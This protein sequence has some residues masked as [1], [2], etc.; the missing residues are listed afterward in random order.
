[1]K[2]LNAFAALFILL[3]GCSAEEPADTLNEVS[4]SGGVTWKQV[5]FRYPATGEFVPVSDENAIQIRISGEDVLM[6]TDSTRCTGKISD[7]TLSFDFSCS[8][9]S[10]VWFIVEQTA[11]QMFIYP[12]LGAMYYY[13]YVME[14]VESTVCLTP[15]RCN[16]KPEMGFCEALIP[17]YYFDKAEGKCKEFIWG[18]CEGVVPFDT[19]EECKLCEC[20]G[21]SDGQ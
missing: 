17:K 14:K 13:D 4:T 18:G 6:V 10:P 7:S 12:R 19:L 8:F 5:A 11:D 2:V 21:Q 1:M 15:S 16:L 3:S 20:S 9:I